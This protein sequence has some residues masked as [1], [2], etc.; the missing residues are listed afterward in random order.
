MR[1]DKFTI[2]SQEL[3]Q[4]AQSLAS[5]RNHQQIEPEHLLSAM[6]VDAQGIAG[7]ILHKLGASPN[8]IA[9]EVESLIDTFPKVSGASEVFISSRCKAVL[10]AAFN[11]ASNMKDE[12]VSI[13]HILLAIIDER[14]GKAFP[15]LQSQG[16][17][18]EAIL[19]VLVEIRG[20]QRIADPNPG[21]KYQAL[22]KFSRVLTDLARRP[23]PKTNFEVCRKRRGRDHA[24]SSHGTE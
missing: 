6:L 19:K 12:Y 24:P 7:S 15:L 20:S 9:K 22:D 1:F 3:I 13:D 14:E 8:G 10:D 17:T 2:K 5:S 16:I 21:E 18:R 11:E 23:T 4:S